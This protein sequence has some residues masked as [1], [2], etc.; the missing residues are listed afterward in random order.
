MPHSPVP[1]SAETAHAPLRLSSAA[2]LLGFALL[3]AP[4]LITLARESWT[5]E[6][7]QLGPFVLALGSWLAWRRWPVMRETGVSGAGT[8]SA[9]GFAAC[10][11][12]YVLGRVASLFLL[13]AY[14]L[15]GFLL[16]AVY[17]LVGWPGLKRGAFPILFLAFAIPAPFAVGWPITAAL[18]Q[19]IS[20]FTVAVLQ[21]CGV[22][23]ARDGL[24]LYLANYRIEIAQ[25]CSGMNSLLAL[26]ALSV[27]YVHLR[28]DA[29]LRHLLLIA[30]F[31]VTAAVGANFLRV[32]LLAVTTLTFG[33]AV[34]QGLSH[35]LLGFATF[36][37]ALGVTFVV[38]EALARHR[39]MRLR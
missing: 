23:A 22:P 29:T 34:A 37:A 32:L 15:Y 13:E 9:A 31:V 36:A 39:S 21:A 5:D 1:S 3:A 4:T 14:A 25:A 30:P 11:F 17:T 19:A 26:S 18:R 16:V 24:T 28:R 33:D 10:A 38:D 20:A 35:Q 12:A 27:C 2:L 6:Q 7:A 8:I